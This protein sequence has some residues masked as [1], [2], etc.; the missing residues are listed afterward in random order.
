MT[1]V[2]IPH[3]WSGYPD[4]DRHP[5]WEP[6]IIPLNTSEDGDLGYI[7]IHKC[8]SN[9]HDLWLKQERN[10]KRSWRPGTR[11]WHLHSDR[12]SSRRNPDPSRIVVL[13]RDP[14]ERWVSAVGTM[15]GFKYNGDVVA[16]VN[17]YHREND[18]L[19]TKN[20]NQ[21]FWP[22]SWFVWD[23]RQFY[24]RMEF[25]DIADGWKWFSEAG[26]EGVPESR[27]TNPTERKDDI[28]EAVLTPEV[29]ARI[30]EFHKHDYAMMAE[31]GIHYA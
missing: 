16:S 25:V 24:D 11:V 17:A 19:Y 29:E 6:I 7:K 1:K 3:R 15:G 8:A 30:R 22:Y 31:K 5:N 23:W 2:A 14:V 27:H 26:V 9:T 20:M 10:W 18:D 13:V 12:Q 4:W 28:R 21:H